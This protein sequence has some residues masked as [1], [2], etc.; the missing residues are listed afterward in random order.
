MGYMD[1]MSEFTLKLDEDAKLRMPYRWHSLIS[2]LDR[3]KSET[4]RG[5]AYCWKFVNEER[6]DEAVAEFKSA[7]ERWN[8]DVRAR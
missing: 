1:K 7:V 4:G 6:Y 5:M 3:F 8:A 2:E